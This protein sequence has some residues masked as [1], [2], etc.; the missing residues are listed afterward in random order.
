MFCA[1]IGILY[2]LSL[3]VAAFIV[4]N[5]GTIAHMLDHYMRTSFPS[6]SQGRVCGYDLKSHPYIYFTRFPSIVTHCQMQK[7]RVCVQNCP[8]AGDGK[9]NC[10]PTDDIGCAFN[11]N[12]NFTVSFMESTPEERTYY[13]K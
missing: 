6:D 2:T 9:L 11:K 4:F 13:V 12:P 7:E 3:V 5:N 1:V 8:K 10:V